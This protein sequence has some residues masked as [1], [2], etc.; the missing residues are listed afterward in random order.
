MFSQSNECDVTISHSIESNAEKYVCKSMN[1]KGVA[2]QFIDIEVKGG[3]V[4]APETS[5]VGA[6]DA[7]TDVP[8][9]APTYKPTDT[10]K[11]TFESIV[12]E[13]IA[14]KCSTI[15]FKTYLM[16]LLYFWMLT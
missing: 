7:A 1:K 12:L 5:T 14:S 13:T 15:T 10:T 3:D 16:I 11:Y 8:T 2:E 4:M 6:T 9:D